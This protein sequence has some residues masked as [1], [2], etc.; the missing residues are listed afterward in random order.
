MELPGQCDLAM[1]KYLYTIDHN[2]K[3][4]TCNADQASCRYEKCECDKQFAIAL[5]EIWSDDDFN[6]ENWLNRK[7]VARRTNQGLPLLD[8]DSVCVKDP[9]QTNYVNDQCCG[10]VGHKVPFSSQRFSCC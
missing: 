8:V 10:N 9:D 3:E 6:E 4:I 1:E 2:T 5:G 7:N